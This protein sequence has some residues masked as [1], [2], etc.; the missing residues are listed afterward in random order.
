MAAIRVVAGLIRRGD[1]IL[2]QQRNPGGT[3]GLLWEFPG[4][5]VDPGETDSQALA[6]ECREELDVTVEV[7]ALAA[8]TEH[9]YEDLTVHL[10]LFECA[11]RDG[12][13]RNL[14]ANAIRWVRIADLPSLQFLPA[15]VPLVER[16][17]AG[18]QA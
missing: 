1:Q 7:G 5:K 18:E 9:A 13:P 15:D 10:V 6:R 16:L 4:G 14:S 8:E 12:E 11:L 3:R 2:V 17:V